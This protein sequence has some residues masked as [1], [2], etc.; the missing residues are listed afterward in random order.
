VDLL[1]ELARK[2]APSEE[3]LLT[4]AEALIAQDR[5]AEALQA[6][7]RAERRFGAS[8]RS[9]MARGKSQFYLKQFEP[10]LTSFKAARNLQPDAEQVM[11]FLT[12][13]E[14]LLG[15]GDNRSLRKP[16]EPVLPAGTWESLRD[17]T[18]GL[19]DSLNPA[20][21]FVHYMQESVKFKLREPWRITEEWLI[22]LRD[23]RG[24]SLFSEFTRTFIPGYDRMHVN[25][26]RVM[27][28]D[29]KLKHNVG[30]DEFY[31][32]SEVGAE[33]TSESQ[34]A[35]LP[36]TGAVAG[37]FIHLQVTRSSIEAS[38]WFPYLDHRTSRPYPVGTDRLVLVT[39]TSSLQIEP[40]GDV[41]R[42]AAA[43]GEGLSW[44]HLHPVVI[45]EERFMPD[46]R[47][48]GS[49]V[50]VA[51]RRQWSEV[52]AE[53]EA[54]IR[55]QFK[56]SLPVRELAYEIRGSENSTQVIV[57]KLI[58]WVRDRVTYK[59]IP[60]GGHSIIPTQAAQTLKRHWGD[61]KDKSL[62]LKE[63]LA[64]F[65]IQSKLVLINL[66]EP[67]SPAMPSIQQFNHMILYIPAGQKVREQFVDLTEPV[68]T[69]RIVP[70]S[71]EGA[72]ALVVDGDSSKLVT[73]PVIEG[74]QE[75]EAK[76]DHRMVLNRSGSADFR[77]RVA[78][79]GK[80]AAGF[81]EK[82]GGLSEKELQDQLQNWLGDELPGTLLQSYQLENLYE[83]DKPLILDLVYGVEK[84]VAPDGGAVNL[85]FPNLWER[86]FMRMPQQARRHHPVRIPQEMHFETTIEM[87][88]PMNFRL[89]SGKTPAMAD[90]LE[91]ITLTHSE[92]AKPE[93]YRS[94][95]KWQ[96]HSV[97][98]DPSEYPRLQSEWQSV[99]ELTSPEWRIAPVEP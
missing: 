19:A 78:L 1:Q 55:H 8:V 65:G 34:I 36:A 48:I 43:V 86:G 27:G 13:T 70:Y 3:L 93:S 66:R 2:S 56:N 73:T 74:S 96:T 58:D 76:L 21:V 59:D 81:R 14:S 10:A 64:T 95:A 61:C 38:P 7:A 89:E 20:P 46:Y 28:P 45:Q 35:H 69:R 62:L 17:T 94:S 82:L 97:Y 90:S 40:Y 77:D 33:A 44:Q 85:R 98:A 83:Y 11:S 75:H 52:G 84:L 88:V 71:L 53:Y 32:T 5:H 54:L 15:K 99:V 51:P 12:A 60:F 57:D 49:G 79:G 31:V 25:F 24:V 39:D 47:D 16:I 92:E 50:L 29:G 41:S 72:A 30:I 42:M 26:L 4:L 23:E 91:Y 67:V 18:L 9:L 37:D 87:Q 80:F 6:T 63:L 22:E 68:G